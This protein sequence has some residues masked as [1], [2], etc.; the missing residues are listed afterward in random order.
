MFLIKGFI[1]K[2][3]NNENSRMGSDP[4]QR[5]DAPEQPQT[6]QKEQTPKE[7]E[8]RNVETS[9]NNPEYFGDDYESRQED[10]IAEGNAATEDEG[11]TGKS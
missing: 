2:D 5:S 4:S 7:G 6:D 9:V 11:Q 8:Y 10:E 1:M 3:S